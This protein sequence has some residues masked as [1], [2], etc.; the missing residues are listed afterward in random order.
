M[1]ELRIIR[2]KELC[3]KLGVSPVSIWRW[4]R[5]GLLP[6]RVNLG[7]RLVGWRN[8]D[9]EKWLEEKTGETK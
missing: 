3:K 6:S 4:E 7:P 8:H 5:A 1:N 9:I 2:I